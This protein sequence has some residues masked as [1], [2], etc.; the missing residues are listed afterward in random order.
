MLTSDWLSLVHAQIARQWYCG[1]TAPVGSELSRASLNPNLLQDLRALEDSSGVLARVL[2]EAV[3]T[4]EQFHAKSSGLKSEKLMSVSDRETLET[5][6]RKL[7]ELQKLVE[8]LAAADSNLALFSAMLTVLL[9]NLEG[10][11]ISEISKE[12]VHTFKQ[13]EQGVLL[14]RSWIKH[15][16]QMARP[17]VVAPLSLIPTP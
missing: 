14:M 15:T 4:A 13:L 3:K 2:S 8:R 12:T 17:A 11:Q 10:E 5:Q 6:G 16:L 7:L 9:H 1:W